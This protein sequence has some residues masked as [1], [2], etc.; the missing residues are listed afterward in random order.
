V[1]LAS[2]PAR[3]TPPAASMP[4][5]AQDTA[6]RLFMSSSLELKTQFCQP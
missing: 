6:I 3:T 5:S 2:A 1:A 4:A